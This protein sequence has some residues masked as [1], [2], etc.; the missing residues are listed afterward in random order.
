MKPALQTRLGTGLAL[1]PRLQQAIRLLQLSQIELEAELLAAVETNPMLELAEFD[2]HAPSAEAPADAD[3]A[4]D[5]HGEAEWPLDDHDPFGTNPSDEASPHEDAGTEPGLHEHLR[6]QLRMSV[7]N[8]RDQAIGEAVIDALDDDGYLR[9][10][11]ETLPAALPA[12]FEVT[13]DEWQTMLRL[14]QQFDPLGCGARDLSECLTLQL[15]ALPAATPARDLAQRLAAG[16]LDALAR[17]RPDKLA[18]ELDVDPSELAAAT[19][20]LKSLDPKPGARFHGTPT[21]YVQPDAIVVKQRGVWRARLARSGGGLRL[22][23]HYRD[24]IG[25][26][27]REDDAYLRGRL[28]EAHWLIKALENRSATLQRVAEAIVR[29]QSAFLDQ[30][31]VAL[32]PLTLREVAEALGLHESTISRATTRKYLRT[33]RGT[34]EFK[35]FFHSGVAAEHGAAASTAVQAMIRAL[36][37]AEPAGQPL[38]DQA[39]ADL[40]KAGGVSVARR[41]VAK[42]RE[43]LGIPSSSERGGR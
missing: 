30:G 40:L 24:L 26:C 8:D 7:R 1:T 11:I 16:H 10:S 43:G 22:N 19:A 6:W 37:D 33:P 2:D 39:L 17:Q 21:E 4:E 35:F 12:S 5:E 18:L 34:F 42:Y 29:A 20:L 3:Q 31:L 23:A 14:I 15:G 9:E 38:S 13:A 41:T 32:R 27:K 36:I 25:H 28:Q